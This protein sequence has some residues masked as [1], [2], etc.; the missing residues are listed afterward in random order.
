MERPTRY[1]N[2]IVP[3]IYIEGASAGIE[4]YK[5]A[6]GATELFRIARPDGRILHAELEI[7]GSV[8]M[9]GDPDDKLY[10]EPRRT[11]FC[12]AGLHLFVDD[13]ASVMQRAVDAG[14]QPIQS[15]AE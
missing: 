3:H 12:T 9:L 14:A 2:S 1:R 11:G 13:N 6:F 4:F 7:C 8:I 15:P 5:R 10:A